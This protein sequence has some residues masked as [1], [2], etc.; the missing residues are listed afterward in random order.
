LGKYD[1]YKRDIPDPFLTKSEG[2][3]SKWRNALHQALDPTTEDLPYVFIFVIWAPIVASF[4]AVRRRIEDN[5]L[6]ARQQLA[7]RADDLE[8]ANKE[9]EAF[10][11]SVSHDLR[12]AS[13]GLCSRSRGS[14]RSGRAQEAVAGGPARG[15]AAAAPVRWSYDATALS[16]R[17][18]SPTTSEPHDTHAQ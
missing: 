14:A 1:H 5:L 13:P 9:L 8:A 7:R 3:L 10:A 16:V 6:Q 2:E 12:D 15:R 4:S 17:L 18:A 11:Y